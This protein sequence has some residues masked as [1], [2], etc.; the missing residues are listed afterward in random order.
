MEQSVE[1]I[2]KND[3]GVAGIYVLY[4]VDEIPPTMFLTVD[5]IVDDFTENRLINKEDAEYI[6][7][8]K[9]G[10]ELHTS[11]GMWIRNTY[12]LWLE[13][14]P[15]TDLHDKSHIVGAVDYNPKHP[16]AVSGD[17]ID[18]IITRLRGASYEQE[19]TSKYNRAMKVFE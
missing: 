15:L 13:N 12:G 2:L 3:A 18:L 8:V 6:K 14:C 5:E 19:Y 4:S 10:V 7:N 16:D 1:L 11:V 9:S 17:I